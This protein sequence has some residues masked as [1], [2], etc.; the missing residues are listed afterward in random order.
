MT[1][2]FSNHGRASSVRSSESHHD[3]RSSVNF[4]NDFVDVDNFRVA[5]LAT[6]PPHCSGCQALCWCY[7]LFRLRS[8]NVST[9]G[10]STGG[11]CAADILD[12]TTLK[13]SIGNISLALYVGFHFNLGTQVALIMLPSLFLH[14]LPMTIVLSSAGTMAALAQCHCPSRGGCR[15]WT[16]L[17]FS[18]LLVLGRYGMVNPVTTW[19]TT[20]YGITM[21]FS[22]YAVMPN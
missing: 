14:K 13:Q 12:E 16:S 17:W 6:V 22:I 20:A 21:V 1:P 11:G 7:W 3:G 4:S 18:S 9:S 15:T 2:M 19:R 10:R 5:R 8:C